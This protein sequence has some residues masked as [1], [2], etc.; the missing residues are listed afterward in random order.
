MAIR[1][2]SPSGS[3]DMEIKAGNT[4]NPFEFEVQ[5]PPELNIEF[6][7]RQDLI[8]LHA[9]ASGLLE[10]AELVRRRLDVWGEERVRRGG[11]FDP[12]MSAMTE[13]KPRLAALCRQI[14]LGCRTDGSIPVL[15]PALERSSS[16]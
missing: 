11:P 6:Y 14:G 1:G 4:P 7:E 16:R 2:R 8:N 12:A 5:A 3:D 15:L 13:S 10:R 9:A